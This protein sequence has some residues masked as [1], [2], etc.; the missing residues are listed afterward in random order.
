MQEVAYSQFL[1]RVNKGDIEDCAL[2]PTSVMF[3][4][5]G[6]PGYLVTRIPRAPAELVTQLSSKGVNFW[7]A[8]PTPASM[9][10]PYLGL[11]IYMGFVGFLGWQMMGKGISGG[12]VGCSAD[13]F[14]RTDEHTE[15]RERES[16]RE[17]EMWRLYILNKLFL[18]TLRCVL[19]PDDLLVT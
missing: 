4:L 9:L 6:R 2:K 13:A 11:I 3:K 10:V 19:L 16:E 12:K 7:T 5:K 18:R 15:E 17:R 8:K 14:I 1:E